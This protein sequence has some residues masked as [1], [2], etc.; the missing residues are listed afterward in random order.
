MYGESKCFLLKKIGWCGQKTI[1]IAVL[2]ES[3]RKRPRR[4]LKQSAVGV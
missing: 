3:K 1:N 2:S 4:C